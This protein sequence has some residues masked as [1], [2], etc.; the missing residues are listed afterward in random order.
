MAR[1][2]FN[3]WTRL[4]ILLCFKCPWCGSKTVFNDGW[5]ITECTKCKWDSRKGY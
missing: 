2:K 3:W 4:G 1:K 5:A